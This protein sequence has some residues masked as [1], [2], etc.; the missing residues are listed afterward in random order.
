MRKQLI[1]V[2]SFLLFTTLLI[3]CSI[4]DDEGNA[5]PPEENGDTNT[6][7]EESRDDVEEVVE[8]PYP[9]LEFEIEVDIDGV[10]D[11][12]E[13]EYEV[14]RNTIDASYTDKSDDVDIK[15]EEAMEKLEPIL[16]TF[17]F[18]ENSSEDEIFEQVIEGFSIEDYD[19][20][21]IEIT[22]KDT[23]KIEIER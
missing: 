6:D 14:K 1:W 12:F 16:D 7:S 9:F 23:T 19:E 11:A 20:L 22:F 21:E 5:N 13:A 18:D 8:A 2:G 4:Y 10:N 3:G 15:N 17:T